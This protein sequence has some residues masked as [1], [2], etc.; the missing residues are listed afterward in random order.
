MGDITSHVE[1][2]VKPE[3]SGPG[4]ANSKGSLQ[5]IKADQLAVGAER[6]P[7]R[8]EPQIIRARTIVALGSQRP[9]IRRTWARLRG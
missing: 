6:D 8:V 5:M 1:T 3:K 7:D 4:S 2:P 9:A